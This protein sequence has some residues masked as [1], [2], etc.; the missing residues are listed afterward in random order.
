MEGAHRNFCPNIGF[1]SK[2]NDSIFEIAN[3]FAPFPERIDEGLDRPCCPSAFL[4]SP[5]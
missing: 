4:L 2:G 5:A 3:S 1:S